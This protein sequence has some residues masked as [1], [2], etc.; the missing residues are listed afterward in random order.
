MPGRQEAFQIERGMRRAH[1]RRHFLATAG[2]RS[3]KGAARAADRSQEQIAPRSV[4]RVF[5]KRSTHRAN[6]L[7]AG[8]V[9]R[10][11]P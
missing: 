7:S 9:F 2:L 1:R 10:A 6:W 8:T 3:A 4:L 11:P 5:L